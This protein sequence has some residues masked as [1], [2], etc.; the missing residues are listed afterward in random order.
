M[1]ARR[2][3]MLLLF[4]ACAPVTEPRPLLVAE[5]EA[6]AATIRRVRIARRDAAGLDRCLK[7]EW[8]PAARAAPGNHA[9]YVLRR[10]AGDA[11]EVTL[12]T[13]GGSPASERCAPGD[14]LVYDV[15]FELV[16]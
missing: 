12:V 10:D 8:I 2:V 7:A 13:I 5:G 15:A 9:L 1:S 14:T 4:A 3:L 11:V 16:Q 6:R